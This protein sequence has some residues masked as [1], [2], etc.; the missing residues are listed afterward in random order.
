VPEVERQ[1]KQQWLESLAQMNYRRVV[2]LRGADVTKING[3]RVVDDIHL[4]GQVPAQAP[5]QLACTDFP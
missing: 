4:A 5:S 1:T 2:F 3:L